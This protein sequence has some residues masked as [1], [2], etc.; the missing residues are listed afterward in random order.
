M[1]SCYLPRIAMTVLESTGLQCKKINHKPKQR[2]LNCILTIVQLK[3]RELT[4]CNLCS[5]SINGNVSWQIQGFCS[6]LY[7][8]VNLNFMGTRRVNR[9]KSK[10]MPNDKHV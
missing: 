2:E 10:I 8:K 4:W 9:Q 1:H 6:P 7:P 3:T 5:S